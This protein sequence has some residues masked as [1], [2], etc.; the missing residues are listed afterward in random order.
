MRIPPDQRRE[1]LIAIVAGCALIFARNFVYLV[2]EQ[3][4]FDSDQAIVGLMAKHLIEGRAFPLFLYG[5]PYLLALDAWIAAPFIFVGGL[6]VQALRMS[7]IFTSCVV[8]SLLIITLVRFCRIRPLYALAAA[9]F[10]A[11]AGPVVNASLIEPGANTSPFLFVI[12]LWLLRDRPVWFGLT[13]GF[14][15]LV[16]EFTIYTLPALA[17]LQLIRGEL[18]T[19]LRI[20]RWAIALV[21]ALAMWLL[22]DKGIRPLSDPM[23]PGTRGAPTWA[24]GQVGNL[25]DRIAIIPSQ[26]PR[27][28][29]AML[30]VHFP[31][32]LGARYVDEGYAS[33][34]HSWLFWPLLLALA[35][36]LARIGLA[37]RG[38]PAGSRTTDF[39]IYLLLV[40]LTSLAAYIATRPAEQSMDR[41]YLFG[42]LVPG[43]IVAW[44]LT[45][46]T[47]AIWRAA[48]VGAVALWIVFTGADYVKL[49]NRYWGQNVP[50]S[51]RELSDALIARNI[52]VAK[53]GYW[54]AYKTTFISGERV[55]IASSDY[56]R[57][58]EYQK[59]ADAQGD[60]LVTIQERP[61]P[62]AGEQIGRWYLCRGK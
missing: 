23:G 17:G 40:G 11:F 44:L 3:S 60:A 58:D 6:T 27:R 9:A 48:A 38:K 16:R 42:L 39:A 19:R 25:T 4:F 32:L 54:R 29:W 61:C 26:L 53:A 35:A 18:F 31:R 8:V 2:W 13:L 62:K 49:L 1:L 14:A 34:G 20:Q 22:I 10:F 30:T 28:A 41:Y 55:K 50:N 5:Q 33:Q 47:K 56:I 15:F 52:T 37:S 45:V 21:A 46:E 51:I 59:L 57:I 12:V 36:A 24:E 43:G 7:A